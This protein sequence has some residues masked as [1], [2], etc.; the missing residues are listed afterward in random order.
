MHFDRDAH[1]VRQFGQ[2]NLQP[3]Q[4]IPRQGDLLRRRLVC[5]QTI[6][7]RL[8]IGSEDRIIATRAP[9]A[10]NGQIA[11]DPCKIPARPNQILLSGHFAKAQIGLLNHILCVLAIACDPAGVT[12]EATAL[13]FEIFKLQ[14]GLPHPDRLARQRPT[15]DFEASSATN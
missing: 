15:G 12:D 2:S 11:D 14:L 1:A 4:F 8:A 7:K 6:Q 9:Q 10:I 3:A 13:L 5:S